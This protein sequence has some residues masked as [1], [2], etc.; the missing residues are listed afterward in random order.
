MEQVSSK[1]SNEIKHPVW[2]KE[3]LQT[4][5]ALLSGY[6]LYLPLP[7]Q[8]QNSNQQSIYPSGIWNY[9]VPRLI[10]HANLKPALISIAC[11]FHVSHLYAAFEAINIKEFTTQE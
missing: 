6:I 2:V 7:F 10:S 8:R 3:A 1:G 9:P 4:P 11:L 5:S